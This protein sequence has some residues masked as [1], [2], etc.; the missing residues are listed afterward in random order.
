MLS[1]LGRRL[2]GGATAAVLMLTLL[3]TAYGDD[4]HFPLGPFRM[5]S[6]K[7]SRDGAVK[8][9]LVRG[10][11]VDGAA[12]RLEMASFGMRRAEFEGQ[13]ERIAANPSLLGELVETRARRRPNARPL[14]EVR[15][16]SARWLLEDGRRVGYVE[17][18]VAV[19]TRR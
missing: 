12:V 3:G 18:P 6:T 17:V 7:T 19:W 10:V 5:F 4:D 2:R 16:I 9:S 1:P 15:L 11:T 14:R 13:L 8:V